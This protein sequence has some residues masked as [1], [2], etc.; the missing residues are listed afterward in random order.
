MESKKIFFASFAVLAMAG[1]MV[2]SS[3]NKTE[4]YT[5]NPAKAHESLV[6]EYKDAFIQQFGAISPFE[7]WDLSHRGSTLAGFAGTRK[8][9]ENSN[10]VQDMSS[11]DSY[12]Y[13]WN[14]SNNESKIAKLFNKHWGDI[15]AAING[16]GTTTWA[17]S[18]KVIFS[19]VGV[20]R[21]DASSTKYFTWGIPVRQKET[22][23]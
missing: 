1:A 7:T 23:T 13:Y 21:D 12:G 11:T 4:E 6:S 22:C 3:C 15:V 17:P 19:V 5:Y 16:V 9:G 8:K 14:Y 2:L 10:I 18:G 20:S